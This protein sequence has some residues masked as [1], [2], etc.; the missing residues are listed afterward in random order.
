MPRLQV[1]AFVD[2]L[3]VLVDFMIHY[4]FWPSEWNKVLIYPLLKPKKDP[5]D[6][7]SYR[8]IHLLCVL[9]KVVSRVVER[10]IFTNIGSPDYQLAYLKRHGT[11]DNLFILNV[12]LDKY[13]LRAFM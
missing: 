12:I 5:L 1:P 11:R 6:A 13:K 9:A 4:G 10:K 8:P 3:H 2:A 7:A